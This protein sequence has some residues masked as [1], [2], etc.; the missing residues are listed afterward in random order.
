MKKSH[1]L[2]PVI[3]FALSVFSCKDQGEIPE[4]VEVMSLRPAPNEVNVDKGTYIG[5]GL[6]RAV[7]VSQAGKI[8]LRYVND[9]SAINNFTY[10]GYTPPEVN[11]LC[12]GPFI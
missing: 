12:A 4:Y 5:I 3:I 8:Q 2:L 10:C 7:H 1:A 11:H 9:T 6:N